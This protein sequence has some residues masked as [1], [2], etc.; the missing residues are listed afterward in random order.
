MGSLKK[1]ADAKAGSDA[2]AA[3]KQLDTV[4][5]E[6]ATYWSKRS[7]DDA[8]KYSED[9][10]AAANEIATAVGSS[11]DTSAGFAKLGATCKGCHAGHREKAADGSYKI[12]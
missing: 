7:A 5:A 12:K 6:V 1:A 9:A 2:T 8:V 10:R 3:A 4:F 11:G